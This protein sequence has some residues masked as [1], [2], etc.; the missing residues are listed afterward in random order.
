MK[1]LYN[2][3]LIY[4]F[5]SMVIEFSTKYRR[6]SFCMN[7]FLLTAISGSIYEKVGLGGDYDN[8]RYY[9]QSLKVGG[10]YNQEIGFTYLNLIVKQFTNKF[11]IA[12]LVF[13]LIINFNILYLVYK[14]SKNIELSLVLYVVVCGFSTSTNII[15]Q[16]IAASIYFYSIKYI[17]DAA[18][19]CLIILVDV[20]NPHT[21]TNIIRQFIA[22]SIY[23][24]SIKYI[25]DRKYKNY[26]LISIIAISFHKTVI[27]PIVVSLVIKKFNDILNEKYLLYIILLNSLFIIEPIIRSIAF[28]LLEN[29]YESGAFNYGSNILHYVV[30]LAFIL[31]YILNM[32]YIKRD[33]KLKFFVNMATISLAFTLLSR[34]NVLYARI[35]SFFNLFHIISVPNIIIVNENYKE[36]SLFLYCILIGILIYYSLL[37]VPSFN[38]SVGNYIIEYFTRY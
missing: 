33:K 11:S 15:R 17:L 26:I 32:K 31:F 14:Y 23:F 6:V 9:F 4:I 24:Y 37:I 5:I 30:Q 19:N 18:I 10:D 12:F 28:R 27:F 8:Y 22:A 1:V 21:T 36:K 7:L 20:L 25:L 16:F 2:L 35:A 38:D 3:L 29:G 34:N 13:M